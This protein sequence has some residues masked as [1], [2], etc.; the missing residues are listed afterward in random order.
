VKHVMRI[1]LVENGEDWTDLIPRVLPEYQVD[2][3]RTFEEALSRL[4]DGQPYDVSIV[5]LNLLD[6]PGS[7]PDLLGGRVLE[8]LR[9]YH[10]G[11]R[12]IALTGLP[13]GAVRRAVFDKYDVDD[14]LLKENL[15]PADIRDVVQVAVARTSPGMPS[16]VKAR[17]SELWAAFRNWRDSMERWHDQQIGILKERIRVSGVL[18]EANQDARKALA[19]LELQQASLAK[20]CAAAEALLTDVVSIED[21]ARAAVQIDRLKQR[22]GGPSS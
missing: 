8:H 1:L 10:P 16:D 19:D 14:L 3:A 20:E 11:T 22:F 15:A 4:D 13:P 12:R 7:L 9:E 18:G 5:D 6:S 21:V 2:V 17:L